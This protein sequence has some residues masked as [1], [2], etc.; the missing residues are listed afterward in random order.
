MWLDLGIIH[1]LQGS[2]LISSALIPFS[3]SLALSLWWEDG[4][5]Q[6][7]MFIYPLRSSSEEIHSLCRDLLLSQA[8]SDY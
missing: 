5:Q 8:G 2:A 4:D 1:C 6:L 3:G 7:Q